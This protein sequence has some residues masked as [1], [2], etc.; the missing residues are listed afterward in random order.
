MSQP[1]DVIAAAI[2]GLTLKEALSYLASHGV[3]NFFGKGY[4]KIKQIIRDKMNEG[5][6]AFTPNKSEANLLVNFS[7]NPTFKEVELLVPQYRYIDLLRTG[8]LIDYYHKNNSAAD[9]QRVN[10]IKIEISKRPNSVKLMKLVDLPGT[11]FFASLVDYLHDLKK[12]GYAPKFLE[13]K[14]EQLI[15]TW[16]ETSMLVRSS[17]TPEQVVNFC[18]D[19]I[20]K[21]SE[22]FYVLGMRTASLIVELALAELNKQKILE[23][24]NYA[25]RLTKST[26]GN[27]PRT[28]LMIFL[29]T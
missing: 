25:S 18:N 6:Y 8:L 20:K 10:D 1:V 9:R 15:E 28:E 23:T 14:F 27:N 26:E 12:A 3:R 24:N 16:N 29:K 17:N 19:Q 22:A 13:E 2:I 11:P 7:K 21:K 4:E 5:K